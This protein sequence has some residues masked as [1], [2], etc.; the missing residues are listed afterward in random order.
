MDF[1]AS[2][3]PLEIGASQHGSPPTTSTSHPPS[4]ASQA[5]ARGHSNASTHGSR[6]IFCPVVGCPEASLSSNKHFFDFAKIKNHLND[7]CTGHLSGAIPTGF[8]NYFNYSQCNVCDKILHNRYKGTCP[9][10]RP[11]ARA[12]EQM[13]SLRS[14][15]NPTGNI[16]VSSQQPT[17]VQ[18]PINLPTLSEIHTKHVPIIKGIP[19]GLRRLWAQCLTRAIAQVVWANNDASWLELQMLPKCTLCRP[20]RAGKAHKSAVWHGHVEASNG[21]LQVNVQNFGMICLCMEYQN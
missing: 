2:D 12:Q 20:V 16:P 14:Q 5:T 8:L 9:K 4:H 13:N 17:F 1:S 7:H 6:R 10:C 18:G 15:L 21:G 3:G 11:S 19:L